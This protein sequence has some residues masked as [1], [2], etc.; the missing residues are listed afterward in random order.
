MITG[1]VA[2]A[3][4]SGAQTAT[5]AQ[6][7][8]DVGGSERINYAGKL[9]MLSQRIPAA[10]CNL[11]AGVG[12]G[13]SAQ[14]LEAASEEFNKIINA[15]EH[16]DPSL[17]IKGRE[18]RRKTLEAIA[19]VRQEWEPVVAA[20]RL[21]R[22][23]G[24]SDGLNQQMADQNGPLLEAAKLLVSQITGAYSDPAA[25][26]Q[27]DAIRID[28]A[29]RQ[30]MLSQRISKDICFV[31]SGVNVDQ[32]TAS[33]KKTVALFDVSHNALQFGK[34]DVGLK[35]PRDPQIIEGMRIVADHW[36][37][38]QPSLTQVL[39]TGTLSEPAR[40]QVFKGLNALLVDMNK[41]VGMFARV[42]KQNI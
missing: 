26:L 32:S 38:L 10:A 22:N 16:G 34:L 35:A 41:V 25:V 18:G 4:P 28:I 17:N 31:L 29:G 6:L 42:S 30:R 19:D 23:E 2:W 3:D 27:S 21:V 8:K 24:M 15:L 40:L 39:E 20:A 5:T 13:A 1:G 33:L 11:H 12:D 9:R 7:L 14:I 37:G 36:A